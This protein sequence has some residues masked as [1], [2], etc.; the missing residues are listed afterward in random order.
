MSNT[1]EEITAIE[2]QEP[3][4]TTQ[5]DAKFKFEVAQ[6][7]GG[8]TIKYCFQCGKCTATCPI[9]R[10]DEK[11]K[12]RLIVMATLLGLR[13]VVLSSDVIWLCA[14]CYSCTERCPQGVRLTDVMRAIRNLAIKEGYVHPFFRMQASSIVNFGRIFEEEGFINEL[15]S[16]LDLPPLSSV[17]REE[18]SKILRRTGVKKLLSA[19]RKG[20]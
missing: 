11:Y 13:E 7:P 10:F 3:L 19:E 15:R 5:L 9:R 16:D 1:S 20:T 2:V 17:N 18:V 4:K 14:A 8:E 12:P 6:I